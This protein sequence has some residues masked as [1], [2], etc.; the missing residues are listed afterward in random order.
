MKTA[1]HVW[2][3]PPWFVFVRVRGVVVVCS[4]NDLILIPSLNDTSDR[5]HP[6]QSASS[7]SI[8]YSLQFWMSTEQY[9]KLSR[10][11]KREGGRGQGEGWWFSQPI[12]EKQNQ[13]ASFEFS[14]LMFLQQVLE[15]SPSYSNLLDIVN[16]FQTT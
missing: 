6:F 15:Q 5:L 13:D 12:T 11:G 9:W 2:C 4:L 8:H 7:F 1:G 3:C 16:S 10:R 14:S